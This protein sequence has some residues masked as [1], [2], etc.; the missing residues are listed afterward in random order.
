MSHT[1]LMSLSIDPK[2]SESLFEQVYLALRHRVVTGRLAAGVRLPPSRKLADE[3][4]VSRT[5]IVTAYDQLIAEG[6]ARGRPGSGVYVSAIGEIELVPGEAQSTAVALDGTPPSVPLRPF[7]PGQPDLRL[8]PYGQWARCFARVARTDPSA[9]VVGGDPFGDVQLRSEICRYLLDW[10]GLRATPEQVM[11]TAGAGDALEKC[12][13][14]LARQNDIIA[15]ENPGYPPL[16]AYVRRLGLLPS[17]LRMDDQGAVPPTNRSNPAL[18][19][20]TPSSQFPLGGAM[21]RGRRNAFLQWAARNGSWIIEDDYDSE[22]RYAGRPIPALASLDGQGRTLY[23]GTFSKVF[24]NGLRLGFLVIPRNLIGDFQGTLGR[25][26]RMASITPQRALALFMEGGEFYRHIRRVRRVYAERH[27][28]LVT[29]LQERFARLASFDDHRAGMQI[30]LKFREDLDD[31]AI[32]AEAAD[33]G[34]TCPPLSSYF[35]SDE[36]QK[37]LLL[38]FCGYTPEEM[39]EPMRV[40]HRVIVGMSQG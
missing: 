35:A 40:L 34:V 2:A 24:S 36:N 13:R 19:V 20:L 33:K 38:G 4:G 23:V 9:L 22:F 21:P 3:L 26:G 16:H 12:L 31:K 17:W 7:Q 18:A 30:A 29:L 27:A 1:P 32:S 14:V 10:R 11:I 15:L 28:I 5:T 8:F 37:G 25:Y 39:E 6:F